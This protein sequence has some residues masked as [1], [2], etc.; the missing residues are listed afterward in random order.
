MSYLWV[1]PLYVDPLYVEPLYVEP[2]YVEP[3]Y[4]EVLGSA[5]SALNSGFGLRITSS[6]RNFG[7]AEEIPSSCHT[8]LLES[9]ICSMNLKT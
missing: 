3:L 1:E 5:A 6:E 2:L 9:N 4:V 8:P 7:A